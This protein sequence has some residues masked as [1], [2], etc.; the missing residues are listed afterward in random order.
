VTLEELEDLCHTF[1][2]TAFR[3]ETLDR[4]AVDVEDESI[5]LEAG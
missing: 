3:L 2:R 4:Y 5:A 1:E